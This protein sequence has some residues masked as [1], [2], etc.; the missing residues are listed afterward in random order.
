MYANLGSSD[1]TY[2][3]DSDGDSDRWDVQHLVED[4][5]GKRFGDG[6]LD[7]KINIADVNILLT[8]FN[9]LGAGPHIGWSRGDFDGNGN[10]DIRDFNQL[11][12]N[13]ALLGYPVLRDFQS[14][15]NQTE[16]PGGIDLLYSRLGTG[17]RKFYP[18]RNRIADAEYDSV[19]FSFFTLRESF[20]ID[21]ERH[22]R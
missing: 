1:P 7:L 13:F 3:L 2:D 8:N 19:R 21:W 5:M 22:A 4:I 10:V 9:P 14:E 18:A 20:V 6:N 15:S 17:E 16:D 12:V 11:L